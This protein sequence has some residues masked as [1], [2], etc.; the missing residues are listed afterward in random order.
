MA[1]TADAIKRK[2][3]QMISKQKLVE[4]AKKPKTPSEVSPNKVQSDY[5]KTLE[6]VGFKF[7]MFLTDIED[8]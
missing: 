3:L 5:E 1:L 6:N 2:T 4:V 7:V 8:K